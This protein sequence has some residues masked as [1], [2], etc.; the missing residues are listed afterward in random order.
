MATM[1]IDETKKKERIVLRPDVHNRVLI[2]NG[3]KFRVIEEIRGADDHIKKVVF[4]EFDEEAH[5][6]R[7]D[8]LAEW[9]VDESGLTVETILKYALKQLALSDL[10]DLE[11]KMR[12]KAKV[13][14]TRGC[15]GL[16][17][18]NFEIE[19]AS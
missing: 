16:K 14:V 4:E 15:M 17:I 6:Q 3:K 1:R 12:R 13:E 11:K 5:N 19:I 18:G 7:I 10:I 2:K 9:L 8:K